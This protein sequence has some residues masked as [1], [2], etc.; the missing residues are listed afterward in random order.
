MQNMFF[1]KIGESLVFAVFFLGG[2]GGWQGS[3]DVIV[4]DRFSSEKFSNPVIN[5]KVRGSKPLRQV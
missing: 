5:C 3:D 2:G 4:S 1:L